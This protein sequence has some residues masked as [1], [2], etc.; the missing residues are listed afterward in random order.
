MKLLEERIQKDGQVIGTEILKVDSFLNHQM[1]VGLFQAMAKEWKRLYEGERITKILTI[2]ASGIGMAVMAAAEFRC[3]VV[4]A[5]KSKTK[6]LSGD[7]YTT[8][9]LSF[10]HGVTSDVLVSKKYLQPEDRI[11]VIDDFLAR[12][13]ALRGLLDLVRQ[14]GATVVGC[15]IA[16]EKCFQQGGKTLREEG[17]RIESLAKIKSMD[18]KTGIVFED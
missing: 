1:D 4:F 14:A 16:I 8:K 18:E 9:V 2:E 3:P 13:E 6:N 15:G 7:L 10:T 5:K 11:L 17:V 12:G